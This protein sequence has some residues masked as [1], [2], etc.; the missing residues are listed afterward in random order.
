MCLLSQVLKNRWGKGW[1]CIKM[2]SLYK[3]NCNLFFII[4]WNIYKL[5]TQDFF[6]NVLKKSKKNHYIEDYF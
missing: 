4:I 6:I 5:E 3:L 1:E 2:L